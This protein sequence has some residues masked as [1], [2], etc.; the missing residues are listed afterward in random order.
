[1]NLSGLG[2]ALRRLIGKIVSGDTL[3]PPPQWYDAQP[4][5]I[6]GRA[7]REAENDLERLRSESRLHGPM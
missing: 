4:G 6:S 5:P 3:T 1:M 7:A 2:R